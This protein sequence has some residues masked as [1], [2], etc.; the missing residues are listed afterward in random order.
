MNKKEAKLVSEI[1]DSLFAALDEWIGNDI[2]DEGT[3]DYETWQER[4]SAIEGI[5]SIDDVI[6]YAEEYV[7]DS[8]EFFRE[9]G[10]SD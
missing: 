10:L 1:K 8:D 6:T 5:E 7:S 3:E 4:F 9:W 2:P